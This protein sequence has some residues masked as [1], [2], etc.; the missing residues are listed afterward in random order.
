MLRLTFLGFS[1]CGLP[2]GLITITPFNYCPCNIYIFIIY[3]LAIIVNTILK[4]FSKKEAHHCAPSYI[5]A[6]PSL[7]QS[8]SLVH[9]SFFFNKFSFSF[10]SFSIFISNF[11]FSFFNAIF[12]FSKSSARISAFDSRLK[13]SVLCAFNASFSLFNSLISHL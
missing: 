6:F 5:P 11:F 12:Y 7:S 3:A 4:Y 10:S 2:A 8:A 9:S 13:R 1:L